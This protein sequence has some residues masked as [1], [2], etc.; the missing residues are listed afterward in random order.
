MKIVEML[1][2][3]MADRMYEETKRLAE[4]N[5]KMKHS[6]QLWWTSQCTGCVMSNIISLLWQNS[7][8]PVMSPIR[9]IHSF[10][11]SSKNLF[12]WRNVKMIAKTPN[13]IKQKDEI[14]GTGRKRFLMCGGSCRDSFR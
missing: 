1:N 10:I 11:H 5:P 13:N 7:I 12:R 8:W 2:D 9:S 6:H 4:D 3:M 14:R